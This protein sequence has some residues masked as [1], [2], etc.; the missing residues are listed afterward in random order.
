MSD[1]LMLS[2]RFAPL[3][4]CQFFSAFNDNFLKNALVFLVLFAPNVENREV[5]IT[6]TAATFIGPFFF[7]SGLGGQMADRFDKAIMARWVKLAEIAVS[8]I[9]VIGFALRS[10]PVMFL[11]L[12]LFGVI[13]TLFGPIKY[14]ILP[15][16]LKQGELPAG[17]ALVEGATFMAILIG[18]IVG[19]LAA[20]D[21]NHPALFGALIMVFSF[22]CWGASTLIPRTGEGAPHLYVDPNI[23]RSTGA[24]LKDMW[25]DSRLWWGGLVTSW[26]WLVGAVA[27]SLMPPL[28]KFALGATEEVVTA[29]L[30]IFTI[31][32]AIGSGLAAWIA[33]GRIVL[34]PTLI[35]AVLLAVFSIDLGFATY[36]VRE[37]A[38][39]GVGT[40]FTSF[41]GIRVAID[42]AGLAIA[43]GLFIVPS[44]A[45]VQSWAGPDKR[46]RVVAAVNVLNAAYIV[47]GTLV[48]AV[49]QVLGLTLPALFM[50]LGVTN[51][52]VAVIIW[53]T[54]S[55][56]MQT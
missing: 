22:M 27:L 7:L 53:R 32:I 13:A 14:G 6:L 2:R 20:A 30:A 18:T 36:G 1:S 35:G 24:L 40:V 29:F 23:A 10:I 31:S 8:A 12:F 21:G 51:I 54:M 49:L 45:A 48:V 16:H 28:V 56:V 46:A 42:L 37:T 39:A 33:H 50:V 11:T 52:V 5:L 34:Y 19:G 26:F 55:R 47:A 41:R 15:D 3:F 4:W 43:G 38:A 44:F 17:N 25:V 9:G